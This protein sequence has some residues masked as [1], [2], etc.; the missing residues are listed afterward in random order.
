[1]VLK[2]DFKMNNASRMSFGSDIH[3]EDKPKNSNAVSVDDDS[4]NSDA[5]YWIAAGIGAAAII[6]GICYA[7]KHC[8]W[9]SNTKTQN[10]PN[11]PKPNSLAAFEQRA[12]AI[13]ERA[14]EI[15][16]EANRLKDEL[17]KQITPPLREDG[18]WDL[19]KIEGK[20]IYK[21]DADE[22]ICRKIEQK[23]NNMAKKIIGKNELGGNRI[24]D[25]S[26]NLV[27][28]ITDYLPGDGVL[29]TPKFRQIKL[30][31]YANELN[32]IVMFNEN[33][34]YKKYIF[35]ELLE[36][37]GDKYIHFY[38]KYGKETHGIE[39]SADNKLKAYYEGLQ[40]YHF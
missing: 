28:T 1:M 12:L 22:S 38:D 8:R 17:L 24:Y 2:L 40:T 23:G 30:N 3:N 16:S 20:R 11:T 39:I 15:I 9:S 34:S 32:S 25:L 27:Q 33:G 35:K 13:K 31:V 7:V 37:V 36:K 26:D 18:A 4:G 19:T 6:G 10:V 14:S 21:E 29:K 5:G